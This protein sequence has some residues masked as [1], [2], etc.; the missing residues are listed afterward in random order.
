MGTAVQIVVPTSA[1]WTLIRR[2]TKEALMRWNT[3]GM[4][5]GVL[6]FGVA[7]GFGVRCEAG[8]LEPPGP[9]GPTM[10]PL[11]DVEARTAIRNDPA[12][13]TPIVISQR[14]SYYLAEDIFAL[15]DNH[16]IEITVGHV[17]LDLN[18][19]SVIGSTEL[20]TLSGVYVD[21]LNTV[22]NIVVRNGTVRSFGDDGV[23]LAGA[24]YSAVDNVRAIDNGVDGTGDGIEIGPSGRVVDSHAIGNAQF[25]IH[26]N[27]YVIMTRV[28]VSENGGSGIGCLGDAGCQITDSIAF[29]NGASGFEVNAGL[30][31]GCVAVANDG[32]DI[33][34]SNSLVRGNQ[35]GS[36]FSLNGSLL[37]ENHIP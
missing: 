1:G 19:Y 12:F 10:K 17:T 7:I 18:G 16:G 23:D 30:I 8:N 29:D 31:Q 3:A 27:I 28:T 20:A 9:P 15:P 5:V 4:S 22:N 2:S 33:V 36:I 37:I 6:V 32:D 11:S 26:P 13:S 14:G 24:K 34:A 21:P 25:G 35:A